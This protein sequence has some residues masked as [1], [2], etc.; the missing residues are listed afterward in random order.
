MTTNT[1]KIILY[2]SP[3]AA[4]EVTVTLWQ[5][6]CGHLYKDEGTARYAGCTHKICACGKK[7]RKFYTQCDD[8][9]NKTFREKYLNLKFEEW[10]GK[11]PLCLYG[12]DKYFF[13]VSDIE[14]YLDELNNYEEE[15]NEY[16][17]EDLQLVICKPN[18]LP[19]VQIDSDDIPENLEWEDVVPKEL[20]KRVAELNEYIKTL[21]PI[22]WSQGK[23]RTEYKR[24]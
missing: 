24:N 6:A 3:E 8:C 19:Q 10:D 23:I 16:G 21:K 14:D 4:K 2:D 15:N 7:M 20:D 5:S 9:Q 22:S 17:P 11:T 13:D 1:D 12:D 18:Y